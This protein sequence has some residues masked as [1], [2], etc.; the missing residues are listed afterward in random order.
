[1]TGE[2]TGEM[3]SPETSLVVDADG[4]VIEPTDLW[5][6]RMDRAKWG[7]DIPHLVEDKGVMYFGGVARSRGRSVSQDVAD[8]KGLSLDEVQE[9]TASLSLAG[10]SD[11]DARVATMDRDGMDA[12][13]L[14][15]TS[16]LF[17]GPLD[18]I[19]KLRNPAF[20]ADCE[21]AYNDWLADYCRA[22]PDRLF[23]VAGVPLQDVTLAVAEA[24]R[25]VNRLG[26]N[27]V[28]IRP[29]AYLGDLP[30]S[31]GAY[32]PFWAACQDLDVPVALHPGVHVDTP[33][34]CRLFRL[35]RDTPNVYINNSD[36][37]PIYGGAALGQAIGNPVDMMVSMGRLLMG[38]VCERFPRLR[39]LFL[40][41]GG[42]WVPTQ[43][44]RMDEQVRTFRLER[45]W[46]SMLPTDYFRRQCWVS[47]DP[48]EWNLAESARFIGP[49]RI[50]WASDY[51]H[52]E[53][54]PEVVEELRGAIAGLPDSDQLRILGGNAVSAYRLPASAIAA[55][56]AAP[57]D[58]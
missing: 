48:D 29:S 33:G 19:E 32:D 3:T 49:D 24:D 58:A 34:A 15:P 26:L 1:M 39:L 12:A 8:K 2:A 51:P 50:L 16:A 36:V 41:S 56:R 14:Y 30:L 25:A 31:H 55:R 22:H 9:I 42:G 21:R 20:V 7:D 46:L 47:F 10:G 5:V 44:Q 35:C 52:P 6:E 54:R 4:H 17:F 11:P 45:Q 40:E 23:G 53:Y 38:G 27:A 18:P 28:F 37:D 57:P 43:L 13:V